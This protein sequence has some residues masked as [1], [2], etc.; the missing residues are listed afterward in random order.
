MKDL[1][2]EGLN[3]FGNFLNYTIFAFLSINLFGISC[4][5]LMQMLITVLGLSTS[6]FIQLLSVL[7]KEKD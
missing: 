5:S 2:W 1:N 6:I 3:L 7:L 4:F